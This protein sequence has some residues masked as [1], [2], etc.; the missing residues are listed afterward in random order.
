MK[1]SLVTVARSLIFVAFALILCALV[2]QFAGYNAPLMLWAVADGAFLRSG[3]IE[4]SLRWALPLFITA[5]GV[6]I[7][8]RAGF[9]NIGAQ[10]QFYVG[11]I[12]A[13]FAAEA[14][15]GGPAFLVIPALIIA[16]TLGGAL[17]A[18]WPGLLRLRSGT[19]EVIT[20]LMGN[21]M[22]GL[23]LVYV[24]SGPLKDPSGSG[25]QAS[26][27]PLDAAYRIS[28][29]L[30]IS[31]T[32]IAIGAAVGILMWLLVNRTAFGVLASLAG[33]NG[34]MVEWQGAR[35]WKLGLSS[36]IISGALA[37]LAGTIEFMGPNGRIASGFLPAHGFTAILIA[38]VANLSVVGTAAAAVFFGGL[39]SAA[40][41]LPIMAG[42]P[43]AA[44][45]IIN[46]AIALFITARSKLVDQVLRL[47]GRPS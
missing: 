4:Q 25:Q 37:G 39:A 6:G 23:L 1:D 7:S 26:S 34:T 18:L 46:A 15:K 47:G 20:T 2:F 32:T 41:Y 33:R 5:V 38:L 16:G 3:A 9:F 27:R 44:I 17:W 10:G 28:D 31:P 36:F 45:D 13:A 30:G 35:L 21:F 8:F 42:L 14:F 29:S 11:A 43:A 24:T 40:L 22:A 19:D 12:C